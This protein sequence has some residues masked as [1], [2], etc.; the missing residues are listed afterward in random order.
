M[1]E[2]GHLIA[3]KML[4]CGVDVFSIG[5]GRPL[6]KK[7]IG[8]TVYQFTPV[9][10]G[11]FCKLTDELIISKNPYAFTN[12]P[13]LKK[14]AISFAGCFI[15]ILI[16]IISLFIGNMFNIYALH[17]FGYISVILGVT[18][19]LPIPALDG[20]YPILVWL[21]KFYGKQK[22]YKMMESICKVGFI[23]IMTLNILCLPYL[24]Y[25]II[26]KG[27]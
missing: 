12:L 5:F 22:G 24:V 1:H 18:N 23:I 26:N 8:N 10:L 2:A 25:L 27:L 6:F 17:Y 20:S 4:K 11:G 16:G 3:A 9:L 7:K 19:L 21:E 13:Y 15:N 14:C